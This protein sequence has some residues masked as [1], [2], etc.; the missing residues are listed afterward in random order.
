MIDDIETFAAEAAEASED[1]IGEGAQVAG[2]MAPDVPFEI[3]PLAL[4][5]VEV[6]TVPGEPDDVQP[7]GTLGQSRLTGL[8]LMARSVV[9]DEEDLPAGRLTPRVQRLQIEPEGGRILR[10]TQDLDP[11][12]TEDLNAPKVRQ[13]PIGPGRRHRRLHADPMP[14]S[15]Q[16]GVGLQVRLILVVQLVPVRLVLHLFFSSGKSG[17]ER[18]RGGE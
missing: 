17:I 7:R 6:G 16:D 9:Q 3:A 15:P 2:E 13:A 18:G 1:L 10:R 5:A 11:A 8:A 14:D 12:A 4:F